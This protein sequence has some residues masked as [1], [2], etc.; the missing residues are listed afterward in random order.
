MYFDACENSNNLTRI[1]AFIS[2]FA[3]RREEFKKDSKAEDLYGKYRN[4]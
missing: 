4:Y 2:L 3:G 1:A